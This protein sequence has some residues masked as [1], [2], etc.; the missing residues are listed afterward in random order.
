MK[1]F[2]RALCLAL[3]LLLAVSLAA[4]AALAEA[5]PAADGERLRFP[6]DGKLKIAVFYI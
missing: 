1:R 5:A 6:K 4:L 2:Y 3:C